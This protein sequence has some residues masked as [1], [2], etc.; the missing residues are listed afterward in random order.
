MSSAA[1][2]GYILPSPGAISSDSGVYPDIISSTS[3]RYAASMADHTAFLTSCK[4][5]RGKHTRASINLGFSGVIFDHESH[6][7]T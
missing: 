4:T 1:L 5:H 6:V 7:D 2:A 3:R